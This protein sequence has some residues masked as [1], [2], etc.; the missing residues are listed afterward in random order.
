MTLLIGILILRN[1]QN[2]DYFE[3]T[4]L[5][6][7][8]R[9]QMK[10]KR[11]TRKYILRLTSPPVP[12]PYF[13]LTLLVKQIILLQRLLKF[14]QGFINLNKS[15]LLTLHFLHINSKYKI[16]SSLNS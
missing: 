6:T 2:M 11:G 14:L 8:N 16:L 13:I 4:C 1:F 9:L 7:H 15:Q 5:Q 10:R 12:K 3:Y